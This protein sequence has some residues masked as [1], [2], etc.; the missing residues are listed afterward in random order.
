MPR[1][2]RIARQLIADDEGASMMEY[3]LLVALIALVVAGALV[4]LGGQVSTMF[5]KIS[6]CVT[7]ASC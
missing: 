2:A 4:T 6:T 7:S 5:G 1:V 3:G